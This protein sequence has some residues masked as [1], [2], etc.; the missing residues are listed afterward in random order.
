MIVN[1]LNGVERY[2]RVGVIVAELREDVT[3]RE[4]MNSEIEEYHA[5]QEKKRLMEQAKQEKIAADKKRRAEKK[6]ED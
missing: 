6:K 2:I 3:A 5:K 4:L 1:D